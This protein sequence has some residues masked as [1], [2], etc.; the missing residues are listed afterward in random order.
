VAEDE[1][2]YASTQLTMMAVPVA[3]VAKVQRLI[4]RRAG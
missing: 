3:L 1:A 2:A 4:T